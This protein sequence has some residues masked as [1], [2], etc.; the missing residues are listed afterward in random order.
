MKF[1]EKDFV[2]MEKL[3]LDK[4]NNIRKDSYSDDNI[5]DFY[6]DLMFLAI[7]VRSLHSSFLHEES[8]PLPL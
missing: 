1:V 8:P 3:I 5:S 4:I 6:Y 7:K 2:L